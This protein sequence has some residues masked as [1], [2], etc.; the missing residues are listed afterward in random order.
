ML[1]VELHVHSSLSYDGRDSVELLLEQAEAV[2]LDAIAV[3]DHDE[4]DASLEAAERAAEYGLVG[5]PGIEI[6]SKAGHILG[7]GVEEAI[8]PGLSYETT[9]EKIREQGGLAVIPHP[10]QESRHGVMARISREELAKGDAIEVYN[11]RLLTGRANRQAERFAKSRNLPM[12]AGS[13]AHIGEM[14]G[15]A[16]TRV[17]A[18]ERS[19][20]AILEAISQGKTSVEGKR[21]PWHISFRQ[22]AGGVTRR[23]RNSVMGLMR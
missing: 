16:V 3:T 12:T 4:I 2:D 17:D 5:I 14:V 1:S 15:Q 21:T 11:S 18:D 22:F 19:A 10:F 6:S 13:D 20:D 23:V 9:L 7:L 8:P